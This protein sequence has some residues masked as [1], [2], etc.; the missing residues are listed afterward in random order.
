MLDLKQ[1]SITEE[2]NGL[3][4]L[5]PRIFKG[6]MLYFLYFRGG[7][8]AIWNQK[9][10]AFITIPVS[11]PPSRLEST[12][13]L[14]V[15]ISLR[16]SWR[17]RSFRFKNFLETQFTNHKKQ[18]THTH[19]DTHTH[20]CLMGS[21]VAA[22]I[23]N[24]P[25]FRKL[26]RPKIH[27]NRRLNNRQPSRGGTHP[28]LRHPWDTPEIK[29]GRFRSCLWWSLD[30]HFRWL[31]WPLNGG[32]E[33]EPELYLQKKNRV[34]DGKLFFWILAQF[35]SDVFLYDFNTCRDNVSKIPGGLPHSLHQQYHSF[36]EWKLW[37]SE[38]SFVRPEGLKMSRLIISLAPYRNERAMSGF[39]DTPPET[40]NS[41]TKK[42][43]LWDDP[44]HLGALTVSRQWTLHFG[45]FM[46]YEES[47]TRK[48]YTILPKRFA[49]NSAGG[50]SWHPRTPKRKDLFR[51]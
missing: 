19:T 20:T 28:P 26:F 22:N 14:L 27:K 36:R 23:S 1:D 41:P 49:T 6:V 47:D 17:W 2:E 42:G 10:W 51:L 35:F 44:F 7:Y 5:F 39:A 50:Y 45:R 43:W 33:G 48:S 18:N 16:V 46:Y 24:I 9:C 38:S 34:E 32:S 37:E 40:N 12:E 29:A 15:P 8:A 21:Y 25:T 13:P 4:N 30:T 31:M 3:T 11:M